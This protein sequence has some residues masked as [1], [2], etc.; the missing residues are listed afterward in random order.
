[1]ETIYSSTMSRC[2]DTLG[3]MGY[4]SAGIMVRYDSRLIERCMGD[5]EGG[6]KCELIKAHPESF[7][8][9]MFDVFQTPPNGESYKEFRD[10]V[11]QFYEECLANAG[12]GRILVCSHNQ[13]LKMLRIFILGKEVSYESWSEWSALNGVVEKIGHI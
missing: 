1:M 7:S 13:V 9:G 6:K 8:N 4:T 3:L 12:C 10:R 2:R 11:H 5:Y